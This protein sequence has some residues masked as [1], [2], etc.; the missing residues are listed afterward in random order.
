MTELMK[1]EPAGRRKLYLDVEDEEVDASTATFTW[2][3]IKRATR[4][5]TKSVFKDHLQRGYF[6][7]WEALSSTNYRLVEGHR[8][9]CRYNNSRHKRQ[10]TML[11]T[12]EQYD[13]MMNGRPVRNMMV[14]VRGRPQLKTVSTKN[15][16]HDDYISVRRYSNDQ[17]RGRAMERVENDIAAKTVPWHGLARGS[18]EFQKLFQNRLQMFE[19]LFLAEMIVMAKDTASPEDIRTAAD[20]PATI[21][22]LI[23]YKLSAT[24][25]EYYI[26]RF[27][28]AR[29]MIPALRENPFMAFRIHQ[30]ILE[31]IQIEHYRDLQRLY[32]DD[33]EEKVQKALAAAL[34]RLHGLMPAGLMKSKPPSNDEPLPEAEKKNAIDVHSSPFEED[35]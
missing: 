14:L 25:A 21:L 17:A 35:D 31:E 7:P 6:G 3:W 15:Y 13:D 11:V 27:L 12:K 28:A 34:S 26:G 29:E 10:K 5:K 30:I 32:G 9:I 19:D 20:L 2:D 18:K 22:S 1:M 23:D 4:I 24:H 16:N 8:A 33:I